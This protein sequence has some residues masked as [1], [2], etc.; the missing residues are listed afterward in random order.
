MCPLHCSTTP[1]P[2]VRIIN[3]YVTVEPPLTH[4]EQHR[5]MEVD[6]T[7]QHLSP[8]SST[9]PNPSSAQ[10]TVVHSS[11]TLSCMLAWLLSHMLFTSWPQDSAVSQTNTADTAALTQEQ[12]NA[13]D[14]QGLSTCR[15]KMENRKPWGRT[16][17][18]S[19]ST[20]REGSAPA[21]QNAK[22]LQTCLKM[23]GISSQLWNKHH[24][25][26]VGLCWSLQTSWKYYGRITN[27]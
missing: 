18:L 13:P 25:D 19:A 8:A 26:C 6:T 3:G 9:P 14:K 1:P 4:Q 12:W 11:L 10:P 23:C 22:S 27:T 16:I 17:L 7:G 2:N 20:Y 5:Q 21:G 15:T 24:V